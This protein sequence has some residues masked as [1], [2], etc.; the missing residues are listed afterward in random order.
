MSTTKLE[1]L[2][3]KSHKKLPKPQSRPLKEPT[4]LQASKLPHNRIIQ[5]EK[6]NL[7][8]GKED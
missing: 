5:K 3:E 1:V 8:K 4:L 6:I 2:K 7:L